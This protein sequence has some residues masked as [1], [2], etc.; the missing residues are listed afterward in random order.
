MSELCQQTFRIIGT[1]PQDILFGKLAKYM[2]ELS[3][4]MGDEDELR[5][6]SI[7]QGSVAITVNL[8]KEQATNIADLMLEAAR[9]VANAAAA[10]WKKINAL[11]KKDGAEVD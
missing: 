4:F 9:G 11:L 7:E 10:S 6:N 2:V 3:S 8:P 5:F 1:T